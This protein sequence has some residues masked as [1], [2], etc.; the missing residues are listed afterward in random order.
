[1]SPLGGPQDSNSNS[2]SMGVD[3]DRETD[4]STCLSNCASDS[5]AVGRRDETAGAELV[6]PVRL[7]SDFAGCT[8]RRLQASSHSVA[9]PTTKAP[10]HT[11]RED[12]LRESI[13][14]AKH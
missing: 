14:F 1:M 8:G 3:T 11:H 10:H 6:S 4:D 2:G 12:G 9:Q 7:A 5:G 13:R